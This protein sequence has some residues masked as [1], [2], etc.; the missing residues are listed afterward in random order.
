[1]A[2]KERYFITRKKWASTKYWSFIS[3]REKEESL[4]DAD[5]AQGICHGC[6]PV[7]CSASV[8]K[9]LGG[10]GGCCR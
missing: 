4:V 6:G 3:Q 2:V 9:A 8:W 7:R 5:L 1:M 10:D